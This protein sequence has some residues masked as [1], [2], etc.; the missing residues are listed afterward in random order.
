MVKRVAAWFIG[1][2]T[3]FDPAAPLSGQR[4]VRAEVLRACR[5]FADRFGLETAMTIDA[6]RLGYRVGEVDVRM[7]HRATGRGFS[8]FLHRG[9]Q[10]A[11]ILRAVL[12]RAFRLR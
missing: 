8:G 9:G 11:D 7:T 5:P 6:A 1:R 12:P 2:L 10:A 3:G 4:A